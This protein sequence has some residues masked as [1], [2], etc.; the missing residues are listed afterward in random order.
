MNILKVHFACPRASYK[1][2]FH[3]LR[4][5]RLECIKKFIKAG[6]AAK[7]KKIAFDI[8]GHKLRKPILE[9]LLRRNTTCHFKVL[10]NSI[11]NFGRRRFHQRS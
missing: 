9:N 3:D 7:R 2:I 6:K 8:V 11:W 10:F 4:D 5:L 1:I